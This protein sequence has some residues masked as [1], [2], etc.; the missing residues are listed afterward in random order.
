MQETIDKLSH[1]FWSFWESK[2]M[3]WVFSLPI[4]G[5]GEV[6]AFWNVFMESTPSAR[7]F[8]I[9][10]GTLPLM[11]IFR[12]KRI[13]KANRKKK[14]LAQ[15][16]KNFKEKHGEYHQFPF[17]PENTVFKELL[18]ILKNSGII[19]PADMYLF[20][21]GSFMPATPKLGMLT[22]PHYRQ[23][24]LEQIIDWAIVLTR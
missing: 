18:S 19:S 15:D 9:V 4:L 23:I 20:E 2:I 21:K 22:P 3:D 16:L 13:I 7:V 1:K 11:A 8:M 24:M 10:T 17:L 12:L 5:A 14:K 6:L